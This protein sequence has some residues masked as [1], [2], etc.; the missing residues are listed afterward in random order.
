MKILVDGGWEIA[1]NHLSQHPS[2][3][4]GQPVEMQHCPL[5]EGLP[6]LGSD[7]SF[8]DGLLGL[9]SHSTTESRKGEEE[10]CEVRRW[11]RSVVAS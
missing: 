9:F 10:Q 8:L 11:M 5:L 7:C 6:R 2:Q 3:G 1:G 4:A